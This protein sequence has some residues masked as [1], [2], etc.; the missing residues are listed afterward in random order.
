MKLATAGPIVLFQI[1]DDTTIPVAV[2]ESRAYYLYLLDGLRKRGVTA[3]VNTV[4]SRFLVFAFTSQRNPQLCYP[5]PG[6]CERAAIPGAI[7]AVEMPYWAPPILAFDLVRLWYPVGP[8]IVMETYSGVL[9][10]LLCIVV[11]CFAGQPS[12]FVMCVVNY[13]LCGR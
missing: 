1:E 6:E 11:W 7:L 5:D 13:C 3:L 12:M 8:M 2:N 10:R 9:M 4:G